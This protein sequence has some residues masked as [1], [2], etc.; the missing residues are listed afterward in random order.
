M[1]TPVRPHPSTSVL[2][3]FLRLLE[4]A[5]LFFVV[6]AALAVALFVLGN[7]QGFLDASLRMLLN[8]MV[9]FSTL[10]VTSGI[11]YVVACVTW[12]I[13]RRH[14]MIARL[15]LGVLAIALTLT[16]ALAGGALEALVTPT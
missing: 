11:C 10:G 15:G 2:Y 13:R 8:L 14:L 3:R 9:I 12:M 1:L 4:S 16:A 6:S 5:T 7:V